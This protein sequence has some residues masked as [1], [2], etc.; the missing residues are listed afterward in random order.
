MPQ[1]N[2]TAAAKT[3]LGNYGSRMLDAITQA[4]LAVYGGGAATAGCARLVGVPA[5]RDC[6]PSC[7]LP[8]P[9]LVPRSDG[10]EGTAYYFLSM[11]SYYLLLTTYCW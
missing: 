7:A 1:R 11:A 3:G 10:G 4:R 9:P 5:T 8:L 2:D 6:T